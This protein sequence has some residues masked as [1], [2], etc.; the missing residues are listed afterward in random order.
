M[1]ANKSKIKS[2]SSLRS[3]IREILFQEGGPAMASGTDPTNPVGFY[4]Y[5]LSRGNTDNFWYRS[6]GRS[7]GTD[8]DPGRPSDASS[9]IGLKPPPTEDISADENQPADLDLEI[10]SDELKI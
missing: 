7:I 9:Y 2:M 5:D 10:D 1:V 4:S 3:L 6:P 8:G